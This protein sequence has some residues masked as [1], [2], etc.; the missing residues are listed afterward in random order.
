MDEV[1]E[2]VCL[3][4]IEWKTIHNSHRYTCK[5]PAKNQWNSHSAR[6]AHGCDKKGSR[7]CSVSCA[8]PASEYSDAIAAAA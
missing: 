6:R 5:P 3:V 1:P 7:L 2:N 8:A 4:D